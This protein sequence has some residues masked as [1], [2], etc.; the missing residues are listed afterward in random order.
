MGH[1][2]DVRDER[3]ERAEELSFQKT[4]LYL[5]EWRILNYLQEKID[6]YD[7]F[8]DIEVKRAALQELKDKEIKFKKEN[9]EN[10]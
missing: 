2:D 5:R 3:E 4:G 6:A 1:Y 7:E 8:M 10:D 9:K